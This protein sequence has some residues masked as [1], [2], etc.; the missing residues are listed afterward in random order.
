M[1]KKL[2]ILF[3]YTNILWCHGIL[4]YRIEYITHKIN[5][6]S[7]H[8]ILYLQRGEL[9]IEA[10]LYDKA[11]KDFKKASQ[12]TK[13]NLITKFYFTK[14]NLLRHNYIK[15]EKGL[16]NLINHYPDNHLNHIYY[17]QLIN[18]YI[19][20]HKEKKAIKIYEIFMKKAPSLITTKD[21]IRLSD[22]LRKNKFYT[23]AIIVLNQ[24]INRFSHLSLFVEK[25][26]KIN[27]QIKAY[28]N[29]LSDIDFLIKQK[30][31]LP[32]LYIQKGQIY[33][34]VHN[35]KLALINYEK[36]LKTLESMPNHQRNIPIIK[37]LK[38]QLLKDIKSLTETM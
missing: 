23:K 22:L 31:R 16:Q 38:Q 3:V 17:K 11:Y 8:Y 6:S 9:Y 34:K 1:K 21:Y 12:D 32:F 25:K 15:A 24:A 4:D 30:K 33:Q 20:M 36:S 7:N 27:I 2:F 14:I 28:K 29:A 18:T 19:A 37:K 13:Y 26:I 35:S 5:H 10:K